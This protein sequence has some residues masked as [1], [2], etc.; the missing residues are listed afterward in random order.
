MRWSCFSTSSDFETEIV[1]LPD[2]PVKIRL[3]EILFL[4]SNLSEVNAP[5]SSKCHPLIKLCIPLK[6]NLLKAQLTKSCNKASEYTAFS[7][8][9]F[10]AQI[11]TK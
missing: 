8:Q 5:L 9:R 7:F 4:K 3:F 10:Y 11:F 6:G 1:K 2:F